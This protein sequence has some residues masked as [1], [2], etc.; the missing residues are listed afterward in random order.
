MEQAANAAAWSPGH[1][2]DHNPRLGG[3]S[4]AVQPGPTSHMRPFSSISR[5]T[6]ATSSAPSPLSASS[7]T[8]PYIDL[9]LSVGTPPPFPPRP[10]ST[11]GE[12]SQDHSPAHT[13][14]GKRQSGKLP[15]ATRTAVNGT[16]KEGSFVMN[17]GQCY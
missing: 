11:G 2:F 15:A 7:S 9:P 12:Q 16:K 3:R 10:A 5:P 4:A 1:H 14:H 8:P 6:S 17:M 13:T